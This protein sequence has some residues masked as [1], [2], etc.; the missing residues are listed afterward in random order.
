MNS[1]KIKI[2]LMYA[3]EDDHGNT[4]YFGI[5]NLKVLPPNGW[6]CGRE[7]NYKNPNRMFSEIESY[8]GDNPIIILESKEL[9]KEIKDA[10]WFAGRETFSKKEL[11]KIIEQG[12]KGGHILEL[13]NG[14]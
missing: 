2:N 4:N 3:E 12:R 5:Y 9:P 7:F 14:E 6:K 10:P 11:E 8:F 1:N 13:A